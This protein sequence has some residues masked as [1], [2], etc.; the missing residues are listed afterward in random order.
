[1]FLLDNNIVSE[2]RRPNPNRSVVNWLQNTP[3]SKLFIAAITA[4]EIQA[5]IERNSGKRSSKSN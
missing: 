4:G 2:L 1:M 3:S 5:G